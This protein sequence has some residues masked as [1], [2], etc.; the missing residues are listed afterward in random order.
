MERA[1]VIDRETIDMLREMDEVTQDGDL[2]LEL[3][4]DFLVHAQVLVLN[5]QRHAIQE[6]QHDLASTSH[7]LKGA[8]L[9]IGALVLFQVCDKIELLARS[10]NLVEAKAQLPALAQAFDVTTVALTELRERTHRGE[11][12]DDLLSDDLLF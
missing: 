10:Q 7:S 5:I 2:L 6:E 12:I 8:S 4:D 1:P 3:V 9:N 11:A